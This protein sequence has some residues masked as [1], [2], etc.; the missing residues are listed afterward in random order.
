MK[1]KTITLIVVA[2]VMAVA[3]TPVYAADIPPLPHAFYGDLTINGS[4]APASTTVEA[5]GEGVTT[6]IEGNPI[7]TSQVGKY[8]SADPLGAKLVV[9]GDI[10]E[11]ETLYF[12][13][14]GVPAEP[15][16]PALAKWHTGWVTELNLTVAAVPE[17]T[18]K[19]TMA[20]GGEGTVSPDSGTYAE[21]DMTI[22]ATAA[23]GWKFSSWSTG[24]MGEIANASS[25]TTTLTLDKDKT[26]TATFT[27]VTV[28]APGPT[29]YYIQTNLFGVEKSYRI[30][31]DGELLQTIE[32]TSADGNLT[33]TIPKD[34]VALD[35][36]GKWL[37]TLEAA[38]DES[39]P[40]PPKDAYIIGLAYDFTPDGATFDPAIT[41]NWSYDPETLPEGAAEED[42][43]IAYYDEDAGKWVEL[44]CVVDTENNTITASVAH[45][46]TFA[47]I[48]TVTPPAPPAPA[49]FSVSSLSVLPAEVEPGETVTITVLVANTGGE[50]GSY[51][52]TLV[53]NDLVEATKEVTVRAGLSKEVTFSVT[54]EEAGSYAVTVDGRSGSFTVVTVVVPPEPAAFSVSYLS[55]SPRRG[56]EPGELVTITVLVANTGG[57]SG[58]STVVLKIDGVKEADVTVTIAAGESQDVTFSVTRE[59]AGSYAVTVDG[60]SGSFTVVAPPE[61][62]EEEVPTKPGINWPLIGGIIGGVIVVGL[63]VFFWMRRRRAY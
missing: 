26:V 61:E 18:H 57:E 59:E 58:S 45:F 35:E 34:T 19:L 48:G 42:L 22:R 30:E 51:Q 1:L 37:K 31:S 41:L 56:V 5:G 40:D 2:L 50:A 32:A 7:V 14:D 52:V 6:G 27:K 29:Y 25:A 11:G 47:I 17:V 28:T 15:S 46:T 36:D 16:D 9:Q 63:G 54:K 44:D 43:F 21:G 23:S 49:A 62:E 55:V 38:V 20:V 12:Y 53:I 24:D 3:A 39:P 8:G 13:V 60:L 4:P 33:I 10:A